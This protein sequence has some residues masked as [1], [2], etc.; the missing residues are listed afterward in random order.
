MTGISWLMVRVSWSWCEIICSPV[1]NMTVPPDP[2][3]TQTL[4]AKLVCFNPVW[5]NQSLGIICIHHDI[6]QK[7]TVVQPSIQYWPFSRRIK[8]NNY[9]IRKAEKFSLLKRTCFFRNL[10]FLNFGISSKMNVISNQNSR[11]WHDYICFVN[12]ML[13]D[14]WIAIYNFPVNNKS[15]VGNMESRI[16]WKSQTII[17]NDVDHQFPQNPALPPLPPQLDYHLQLLTAF[18]LIREWFS[19]LITVLSYFLEYLPSLD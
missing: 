7:C 16:V 18:F 2:E 6:R 5:V 4:S 17:S 8:V 12:K 14:N 15:R 3:H 10:Y 9:L 19:L 13:Y 11:S 1:Y